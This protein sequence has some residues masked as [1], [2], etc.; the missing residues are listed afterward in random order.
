MTKA[1]LAATAL[2]FSMQ[3][4][5][6][7]YNGE[8]MLELIEAQDRSFAG[9]AIPGDSAKGSVLLGYIAGVADFVGP[10]LLCLPP[11]TTLKQLYLMV[12]KHIKQHPEK[13]QAPGDSLIVEAIFP[14]Y[15]CKAK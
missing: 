9:T 2:I 4:N 7:Y 8:R 6:A 3:S 12:S 10:S 1:L 11:E 15:S 13:L 14:T 5:A